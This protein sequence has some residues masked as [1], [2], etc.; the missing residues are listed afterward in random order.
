M[1]HTAMKRD[2]TIVE[3][4]LWNNP[5]HVALFVYAMKQLS[6]HNGELQKSFIE[7]QLHNVKK[8]L[9]STK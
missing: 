6:L 4:A 9:Q 7:E 1:W 3:R 5:L 2:A 8:E